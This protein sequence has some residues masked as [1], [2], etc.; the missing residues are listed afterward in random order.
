M[1][2][3]T[4]TSS[5]P[6][7]LLL[8]AGGHYLELSSRSTLTSVFHHTH[9]HT[10]DA[11]SLI[12]WMLSV[13]PHE[14]PSI[15]QVLN[16]PWLRDSSSTPSQGPFSSSSSSS[17]STNPTSSSSYLKTLPYYSPQSPPMTTSLSPHQ[18]Y[19]N[20]SYSR[21][22][23]QTCTPMTPALHSPPAPS[24]QLRSHIQTRSQTRMA[25]CHGPPAVLREGHGKLCDRGRGGRGGRSVCK[26]S[27]EPANGN[28]WINGVPRAP[29]AQVRKGQERSRVTRN[30]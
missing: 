1:S 14:R 20:S 2:T 10:T 19:H 6:P 24:P 13:R 9:A 27:S 28:N 26:S 4:Y 5:L 7:V 22:G 30:K 23:S 25:Q 15:E 18:S 8:H 16:H 11:E 3:H 29:S 12:R 21:G 17:S